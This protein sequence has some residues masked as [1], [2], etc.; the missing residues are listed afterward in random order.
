MKLYKFIFIFFFV[1]V[2][3]ISAKEVNVKA[4]IEEYHSLQ[5][6]LK[7]IET[8]GYRGL[9]YNYNFRNNRRFNGQFD[10]YQFYDR[11]GFII[12][13]RSASSFHISC[14]GF[15]R[16]KEEISG[17]I[18]YTR[19]GDFRLIEGDF[20]LLR[21]TSNMK[22]IR[23]KLMD[24]IEKL[25]KQY[26]R[27]GMKS[28]HLYSVYLYEPKK[29][30]IVSRDGFLFVFEDVLRN[31]GEIYSHSL[32]ASTVNPL[33]SAGRM[34]EILIIL[35]NE[36]KQDFRRQRYFLNKIIDTLIS[37]QNNDSLKKEISYGMGELRGRTRKD[38]EYAIDKIHRM[39]DTLDIIFDLIDFVE[40]ERNLNFEESQ[41]SQIEIHD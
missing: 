26:E 24:K 36:T 29:E 12:H 15:F 38:P 28:N 33:K 37:N 14:S 21:R 20:F 22:I 6:D 40:I 9:I 18:F 16:V 31:K 39:D 23:Y 34:M 11:N 7:N 5:E 32:E 10:D 2:N 17:K 1:L 19:N 30:S 13:N 27:K 4:L 3:V 35:E 8:I 41:N 25:E